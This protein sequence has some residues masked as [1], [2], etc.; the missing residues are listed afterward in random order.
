MSQPLPDSAPRPLFWLHVKKA[1]GQSVRR[2]LGSSYVQTNRRDPRPLRTTPPEQRNDWINNYRN[3]LGRYDYHRM[4]FARDKAYAPG[5]FASMYK[6]TVVRNPYDRAVSMWFYL[7][8][9]SEAF[10]LPGP[11]QRARFG[12]FLRMV[13]VYWAFRPFWRRRALHTRPAIPDLC[14]RDNS[15]LLV[16]FVGR[17]ERLSDD[18]AVVCTAVGIAPP[19]VEHV[20]ASRRRDSARHYA[21][22]YDEPLRRTVERLYGRDIARFKYGFGD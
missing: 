13:P 9:R 22:Y 8:S 19:E 11:G 4:L 6:F 12:A 17:V 5:V 21:E 15:T 18:L 10:A 16:D 20:N 1:A 2:A 7:D 14:D 3:H